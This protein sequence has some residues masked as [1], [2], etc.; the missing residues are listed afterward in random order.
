MLNMLGTTRFHRSVGYSAKLKTL[1]STSLRSSNPSNYI[2][3]DSYKNPVSVSLSMH[4]HVLSH[5]PESLNN[6]L[7]ICPAIHP[8]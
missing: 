8:I 6:K 7:K 4:V 2:P 3:L 5:F 1:N